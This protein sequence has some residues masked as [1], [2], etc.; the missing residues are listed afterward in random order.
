MTL[1]GLGGSAPLGS[2]AAGNKT[3]KE[4]MNHKRLI[5]Q[6]YETNVERPCCDIQSMHQSSEL[7][8]F[9]GVVE[10]YWS[11]YLVGAGL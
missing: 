10:K 3:P 11:F 6:T 5:I 4:E 9:G 1:G 8:E 2:L 7:G